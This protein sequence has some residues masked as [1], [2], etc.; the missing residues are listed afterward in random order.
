MMSLFVFSFIF[1]MAF[2]STPCSQTECTKSFWM[3]GS[4][5][6]DIVALK[7]FEKWTGTKEGCIVSRKNDNCSFASKTYTIFISIGE[8]STLGRSEN[9]EAKPASCPPPGPFCASK[10]GKLGEPLVKEMI[11]LRI[12]Y[13]YNGPNMTTASPQEPQKNLYERARKQANRHRLGDNLWVD[14]HQLTV[15]ELGVRNCWICNGPTRDG[16]WPW[17]DSDEHI[18]TQL[19]SPIQCRSAEIGKL[20]DWPPERITSY[21]G[22]A[23]WAQDGSWGYRTPIYMLNRLIRL[24]ADLEVITNQTATALGLLAEEHQQIRATVYQNRLALDYLLAAEGGV[25][26]KLNLSNCCL[27]IDN[28]GQAVKDFS[29]GLRKLSHVPVQTWHPAVGSWL[30]TWFSGSWSWIHLALIFNAFI[31]LALILIPC[32]LP[33]LQCLVRQA[34]RQISLIMVLQQQDC[35][36]AAGN[37]LKRWEKETSIISTGLKA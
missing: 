22:P 13:K 14:L 12:G 4:T 19:H 16:T 33:C 32:I 34:I 21:Y 23:T 29:S 7:Y 24:Q 18:S 37:L 26:G 8:S 3:M 25:C 30:A 15:Q 5:S 31:L 20:D 1:P 2:A 9:S 28:N 17:R 35:A 6:G 36:E 10:L 11:S 27:E